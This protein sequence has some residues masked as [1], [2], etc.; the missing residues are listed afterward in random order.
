MCMKDEI[1]A[2]TTETS[3]E[4]SAIKQAASSL[5]RAVYDGYS[6]I[7]EVETRERGWSGPDLDRATVQYN[8][9]KIAYTK[10]LGINPEY[11][12][13]DPHLR[14]LGPVPLLKPTVERISH[15]IDKSLE[16]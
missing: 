12:D 9:A 15:L 1:I 13:V 5:Q 8:N 2:A 3:A 16:A 4:D 11:G 14:T 7:R 10:A 6:A